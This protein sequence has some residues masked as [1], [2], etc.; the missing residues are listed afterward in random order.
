[1]GNEFNRSGRST[2]REFLKY[3]GKIGLGGGVYGVVGGVVGKGYETVVD[4]YETVIEELKREVVEVGDKIISVDERIDEL[5]VYRPERVAKEA[6]GIRGKLWR[7]LTG[8]TKK[9]QVKW[10]EN[11]GLKKSESYIEDPTEVV[12]AV[13]NAIDP[14]KRTFLKSFLGYAHSNSVEVGA[15]VGAGYGSVSSTIRGGKDYRTN[16]RIAGLEDENYELNQRIGD[17][18]KKFQDL[19]K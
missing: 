11:V 9:D 14:M 6:E 18:E 8:R 16:K 5:P 12:P 3:A 17:L 15:V 13:E 2:R 7:S 4:F 1:M 10:V 19:E